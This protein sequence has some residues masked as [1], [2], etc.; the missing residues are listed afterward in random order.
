[1]Y[2]FLVT[3][4]SVEIE[5]RVR[6]LTNSPPGPVSNLEERG[7]STSEP[8]SHNCTHLISYQLDVKHAKC[9]SQVGWPRESLLR[10]ECANKS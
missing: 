1:M 9:L 2:A 6:Q 3:V 8:A 10:H 4:D 7:R 5:V